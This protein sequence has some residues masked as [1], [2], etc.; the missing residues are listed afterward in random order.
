MLDQNHPRTTYVLEAAAVEDRIRLLI[1]NWRDSPHGA[2]A[3]GFRSDI[4]CDCLPR[5]R[6]LNREHFG[7]SAAIGRTL[8][9]LAEAVE[10]DDPRRSW[11]AF[12][13]LAGQPG[14]NF[15]TWAI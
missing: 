9:R 15:G 2:G 6:R 3:E 13:A 12:M 7:G 1:G 10:A 8:D 14:D 11:E 4:L 5:L